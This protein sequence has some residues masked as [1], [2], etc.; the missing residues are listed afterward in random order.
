MNPKNERVTQIGDYS[1]EYL[2]HPDKRKK[3]RESYYFNWVDIKNKISGF[4]TLGIVPNEKKREL[5]FI[6]F[7]DTKREVYYREPQLEN[8]DYDEQNIGSLLVDKK[9]CYSII[10]PLKK[11]K[12][13]FTSRKF[14]FQITFTHRFSPYYF[15]ENSSASWHR[16][17]ECSG[18]INGQLS[19]KNGHII[20]I[21]GYGQRDKSWGYRDWHSF[22]K[23]Y[24]GHFQFNKWCCG[25]RKDY[26]NN[27]MQ[28]SGYI[29][30]EKGNYPLKEVL[31]E[32]K[33]DNDAFNSP[34]V[35]KYHLKAENGVEFRIKAQRITKNSYMRF[36][37]EFE[38]GSTELFEQMVLLEDL[39]N[40]ETGTGMS[41]ELRTHL[42][43]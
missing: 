13:D 19:F 35:T 32:V 14:N 15:G 36:S 6:L 16:H 17:F 8:Y 5:V 21:K 10:E 25:F 23:W 41:E 7:F 9:L 43:P 2:H 31:V 38:G 33:T 11:W 22:D 37:R 1:D 39:S 34:L 24:A 20:K 42:S 3:W 28:L 12:I 40:G 30:D 4:T 27:T 29:G 26:T 18:Y